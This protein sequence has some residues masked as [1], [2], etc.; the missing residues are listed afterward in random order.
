MVANTI[1]LSEIVVV[2]DLARHRDEFESVLLDAIQNNWSYDTKASCGVRFTDLGRETVAF[3][4]ASMFIERLFYVP[5]YGSSS[6][7]YVCGIDLWDQILE[8]LNQERRTSEPT[9]IAH[10]GAG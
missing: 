9:M 3:G 5:T 1:N 2:G 4:A 8:Q 10:P 6:R 7:D